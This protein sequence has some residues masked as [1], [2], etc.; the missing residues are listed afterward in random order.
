MPSGLREMF[1]KQNQIMLYFK[2]KNGK[3][4]LDT[5]YQHAPPIPTLERMGLPAKLVSFVEKNLKYSK[6]TPF[7]M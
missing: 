1:K 6:L 5:Q 7:Q 2:E 4:R 3:F